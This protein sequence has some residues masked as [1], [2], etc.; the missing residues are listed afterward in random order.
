MRNE[1]DFI[2]N[3]F[4]KNLES[5]TFTWSAPSNIALVKY[6]GKKAN[7][8]PA[9]PSVSFTFVDSIQCSSSVG[10]VFFSSPIHR[11]CH[12]HT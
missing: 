10:E 5:G 9:N 2:P 6:W 7:Q 12:V 4:S 8:I 3:S 1:T 11:I